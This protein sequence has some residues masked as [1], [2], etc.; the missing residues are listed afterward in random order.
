MCGIFAYRGTSAALELPALTAAAVSAGRRGPHGCG[1]AIREATPGGQ[2]AVWHHPGPLANYIHE[3]RTAAAAFRQPT[4][5]GHARL[6]T[7]G[8]WRDVDQLQPV[9][10]DGHALAHNGVISNPDQLWPAGAPTDSIALARAYAELR[11]GHP[12]GATDRRAGMH[13][14]DALAKLMATAEQQAW[15]VVVLDTDG[16]L[17]AH[18]HY[19]PLYAVRNPGGVYLSSQRF[20]PRCVPLPEDIVVQM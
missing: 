4:I 1:W 14:A 18:R 20:G 11:R 5:L 3:L 7:V 19:H 6:A 16:H 8:D 9:I 13:P 17:Y 15:A 12:P 2:S 10:A